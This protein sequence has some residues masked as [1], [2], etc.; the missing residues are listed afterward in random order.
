M[1]HLHPDDAHEQLTNIV[2]ALKPG[3][4]YFCRT[5]NRLSGPHDISGLFDTVARGLHLREYTLGELSH[6]FAALGLTR[7][8]V[9]VGGVGHYLEWPLWPTRAFEGLLQ[10]L[11]RGLS[12]KLAASNPGRAMLGVRLLA[13]KA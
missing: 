11:P 7:Q 12:R 10:S 4:L 3:G 1:E 2:T 9:L 5:P 8:S 6:Q 13:R